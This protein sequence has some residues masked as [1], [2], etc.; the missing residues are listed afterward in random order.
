MIKDIKT[1]L[2]V[3]NLVQIRSPL[4]N[5]VEVKPWNQVWIQVEDQVRN[6][7]RNLVRNQIEDQIWDQ[8]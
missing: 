4:W 7:V 2:S 5:R 8:R 6:L 1:T 3:E